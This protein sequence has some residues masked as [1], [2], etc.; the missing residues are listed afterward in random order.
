MAAMAS[1]S[2]WRRRKWTRRRLR[3]THFGRGSRELHPERGPD[4]LRVGAETQGDMD[5]MPLHVTGCF[6]LNSTT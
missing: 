5:S 1:S 3:G 2:R 6:G 4:A